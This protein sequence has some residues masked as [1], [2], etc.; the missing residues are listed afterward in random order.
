MNPRLHFTKTWSL[1]AFFN[2]RGRG[3]DEQT[4]LMA[5]PA[6]AS[7]LPSGKEGVSPCVDLLR[8]SMLAHGTRD[9]FK[10]WI[11]FNISE[12]YFVFLL[13]ISRQ[14]SSYAFSVRGLHQ[15]LL[16]SPL[17][18][19]PLRTLRWNRFDHRRPRVPS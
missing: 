19:V 18:T 2:R 5:F 9:D 4:F 15:S 14:C 7:S 1:K 16:I 17:R 3:R 10:L 13:V 11:T 6:P 12:E 8:D